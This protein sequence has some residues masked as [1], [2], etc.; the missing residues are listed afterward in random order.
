MTISF[1]RDSGNFQGLRDRNI[2]KSYVDFDN[3]FNKLSDYINYDLKPYAEILENKQFLG[4]IG[5]VNYFLQNISDGTTIFKA[6]N[7]NYLSKNSLDFN[8][9]STLKFN[10]LISM[11][12]KYFI[13]N[14]PPINNAVAIANGNFNFNFNWNKVN[15]NL[16]EVNSISSDK[17]ELSTLTINHITPA[18]LNY[19]LQND[20][21]KTNHIIDKELTNSKIVGG[22]TTDRLTPE[23][24]A[25]R[26]NAPTFLANSIL[27]NNIKINSFHIG[28]W[29]NL[30]A[31]PYIQIF[32]MVCVP[33]NSVTII[34]DGGLNTNLFTQYK[35]Q[36]Y[37]MQAPTA[38]RLIFTPMVKQTCIRSVHLKDKTFTFPV[39][40]GNTYSKPIIKSK[41]SPELYTILKKGGLV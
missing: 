31:L 39:V 4:E 36:K 37:S 41:L 16:I 6:F 25:L 32:S 11:S 29:L 7:S 10:S 35:I 12:D 34:P 23:L 33:K 19:G 28:N 3:E 14:V 20:S 18:I 13:D 2:P 8:I 30:R 17:V 27:A 24:I 21:I 15:N 38:T 26:T 40:D 9:F 22:I 5:K 1:T